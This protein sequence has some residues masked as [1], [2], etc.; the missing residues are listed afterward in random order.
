MIVMCKEASSLL[1]RF[2]DNLSS[3]GLVEGVDYNKYSINVADGNISALTVAAPVS[4][5]RTV[6]DSDGTTIY[7]KPA[8][9]LPLTPL[10]VK[11]KL[12]PDYQVNTRKILVSLPDGVDFTS[13]CGVYNTQERSFAIGYQY[14]AAHKQLAIETNHYPWYNLDSFVFTVKVS[15]NAHGKLA[16]SL[17]YCIV[18]SGVDTAENIGTAEIAA[19]Q[20]SLSGPSATSTGELLVR[21]TAIPQALVAFYDG[22]TK[23]GEINANKAGSF[24]MMLVL[25]NPAPGSIHYLTAQTGSG[26]EKQ[27]SPVLEI[28]YQPLLPKITRLLYQSPGCNPVELIGPNRPDWL[29]TSWE[30]I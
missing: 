27:S 21:G 10:V 22:D 9:N 19:P 8:Y 28:V 14:D 25:S 11:Y 23:L 17:Q 4:P 1:P 30:I 6:L 29:V 2:L 5:K 24:E 20:I 18:G 15:P 26:A 13:D 12:K 3:F 16:A 7:A